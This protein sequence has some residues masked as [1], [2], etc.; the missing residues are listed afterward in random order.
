P[1]LPLEWT[2]YL[3]KEPQTE[4]TR[5]L[6]LPLLRNAAERERLEKSLLDH[7]KEKDW[8]LGKLLDKIESS[9][10]DLSTVFPGTVSLRASKRGTT[11]SQAAKSIRGAAPFDAKAW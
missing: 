8:V 1:L 9:G 2:L 11:L 10:L 5:H 4:L 7:L 6:L 3:S